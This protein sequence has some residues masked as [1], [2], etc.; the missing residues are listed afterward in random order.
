M[1]IP[2]AQRQVELVTEQWKANHI[3]AMSC[4][5]VEDFLRLAVGAFDWIVRED[6]NYR[7]DVAKGSVQ[8]D[9]S[10]A[11]NILELFRQWRDACT[12]FIRRVEECERLD[13][14]VEYASQFRSYLREADGILTPDSE[15][16]SHPA[17]VD[18]R[19]AAIDDFRAGS[20]E[21]VAI[22]R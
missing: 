16:L 10:V 13:F 14:K 12:H 5:D 21:D 18:L 3:D 1:S 2:I 19:D 4:R 8:Y 6:E 7:S 22:P 15:F 17:L 20:C 9:Q 11:D